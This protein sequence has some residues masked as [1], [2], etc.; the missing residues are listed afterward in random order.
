MS[1]YINGLL[2]L[3]SSQSHILLTEDDD[4]I[5]GEDEEGM[6]V[7][8]GIKL[9]VGDGREGGEKGIGVEEKREDGRTEEEEEEAEGNGEVTELEQGL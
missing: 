5:A 2:P 7:G 1:T 8:G 3:S 4:C 6:K 9:R